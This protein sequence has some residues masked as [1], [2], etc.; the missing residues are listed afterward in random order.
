MKN[1]NLENQELTES[2]AIQTALEKVIKQHDK[3]REQL[4]PKVQRILNIL[5][6]QQKMESV[7]IGCKLR[8]G[9]WWFSGLFFG[10]RCGVLF[11]CLPLPG[12]CLD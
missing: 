8:S 5:A 10:I 12:P 1:K 6:Q 2:E 11:R 7:F 4:A 3:Q 9:R